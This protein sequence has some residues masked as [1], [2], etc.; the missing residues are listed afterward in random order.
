M[1]A[2]KVQKPTA[3]LYFKGPPGKW[4]FMTLSGICRSLCGIERGIQNGIRFCRRNH[5]SE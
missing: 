2:R 5:E 1:T 3:A 4:S